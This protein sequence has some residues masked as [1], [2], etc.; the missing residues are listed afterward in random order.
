MTIVQ[1][2]ILAI[3]AIV[4]GQLG[5]GRQLVLLAAS[6]FLAY[7]LQS[8]QPF[9]TLAFWLPTATLGLTALLW[10]VT[11]L[12]ETG[13]W[14]QNW[15]AVAVISAVVLLMDANRYFRLEEIYT[16][17]TPRISIVLTVMAGII[18]AVFIVARSDK[19]RQFWPMAAL[20]GLIMVFILLKT[21]LLHRGLNALFAGRSQ[22]SE[23][24]DLAFAWLGFSYVAFRL[25][26]TVR[27]RQTGRLPSVT[28]SEYVNYVI[29]FPSFT[30]GPIDRLERFRQD[31]QAGAPLTNDDW[32]EAGTRLFVGLFKKF[33]VADLLAIISI[34]DV[35]VSQVKSAAWLWLFLYAYTFRIYFDFSGYT[36]V[37]IVLGRL[38][39]F[40][41]PENFAG[42]YLKPNI[43]QFWNSW[44][45]T[46][47]QWFRSYFFNPLTRTLR[48]AKNPLPAP[49][50][51]LVTQLATMLLI[52]LWH[53]VTW[54]FVAW[55]LWHGLGLFIHNRWTD[56]A[57][58]RWPAA[59]GGEMRSLVGP[60]IL[61]TLLTFH[62]VALGW[63]FFTLS[64]PAVALLAIQKLFGLR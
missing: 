58:S 8:P 27:D 49:Y 13:G 4:I 24:A 63:L 64:S 28:L 12:P 46:L 14:R 7:W 21:P 51:I 20:L 43:T 1:I 31:L 2:S 19:T 54:G 50:I 52:G 53:G 30:A 10:A 45:M 47:T 9:V 11:C 34:S 37:A 29:F 36:D 44:H 5:K 26:H 41:L 23:A 57:R 38:M 18:A 40:R 62:F 15:P 60:N 59:T 25:I 39:G 22:N 32:L 35:L 17:A 61:G 56:F 48:S 33:V 3:L 42:P 6:A 55:G 16:T